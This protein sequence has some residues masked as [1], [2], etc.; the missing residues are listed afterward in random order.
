[1]GVQS[2]E[3]IAAAS[4]FGRINDAGQLVAEQATDI[5]HSAEARR[6]YAFARFIGLARRDWTAAH[7]RPGAV[8]NVGRIFQGQGSSARGAATTI[9]IAVMRWDREGTR[10]D[11]SH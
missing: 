1:M 9:D 10:R 3:R 4:R 7:E 11:S 5:E 6:L 2:L 8:I